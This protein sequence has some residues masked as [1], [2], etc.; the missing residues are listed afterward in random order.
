MSFLAVHRIE[1]EHPTAQPDRGDQRLCRGN[2]VGFL[3]DDLVRNDDLV[4]DGEG[5]E[6]MR[7]L[8]VRKSIETLQQCL[9]VDC[10]EPRGRANAIPIEPLRRVPE[11]LLLFVRIKPL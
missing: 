8:A 6:D 1:R 11:R 10:S 5:A 9:S 7:R 2:L 4:I 3:V